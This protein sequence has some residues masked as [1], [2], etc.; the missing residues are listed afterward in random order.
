M[1]ILYYGIEGSAPDVTAG[2]IFL[3][4]SIL[5]FL[6]VIILLIILKD[7]AVLVIGLFLIPLIAVTFTAFD[8]SRVPIIKATVDDQVPW[9][10][11]IDKYELQKQEGLLYTFKVK[12]VSLEEW[13]KVVEV[14][15]SF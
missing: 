10:N 5:I 2:W 11:I 12:N 8:D 7:P 13:E 9:S 15:C 6:T 1:S 3:G 14:Q 4:L